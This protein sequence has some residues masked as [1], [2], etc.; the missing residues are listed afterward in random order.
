MDQHKPDKSPA[1]GSLLASHAWRAAMVLPVSVFVSYGLSLLSGTD[2][3]EAL[4]PTVL[5]LT[6]CDWLW[7]WFTAPGTRAVASDLTQPEMVVPDEAKQGMLVAGGI[8]AAILA[9]VWLI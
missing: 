6:A 4:G 2:W 3:W 1:E 5:L 7:R 9:L 8:V